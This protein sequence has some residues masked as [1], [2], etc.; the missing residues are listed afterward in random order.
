MCGLVGVVGNTSSESLRVAAEQMSDRL[1]HRGPDDDGLWID[2]AAGVALGHRRLAIVDL[3]PAGHQPMTSACGRWVLVFNGEIYNHA[4]LRAELERAGTAT[5]WRGH[6]DT[7]TLLACFAA[8]GIAET[9]RRSVGMFA[10]GLW[11]RAERRLVLARD[12][13]GEKP[14]YY[15]WGQAD[16]GFVL[17]FASEL[18]ALRAFPGFSNPIDRNALALYFQCGGL[19]APHAIYKDVFKVPPGHFL[20]FEAKDLSLKATRVESYW[21]LTEVIEAGRRDP[22]TDDADAV[23]SLDVALREAIRLQMIADVPLGVF[24]SG[25]VDSSTIAALMQAQSMR[26]VQTFTI[27]FDKAQFNEGDN[28]GAVA[29]HLGTDHTD[30]RVTAQAALA[31]APRLAHLIDEPFADSSIIPTF[32]VCEAARRQVTVALSGDAGDELF[33]GYNRH[34]FLRRLWSIVGRMPFPLRRAVC[35]A[36]LTLPASAL[37]RLGGAVDVGGGLL[38]FSDK[39]QK[40]ARALQTAPDPDT[41]YQELLSYWPRDANPALGAAPPLIAGFEEIVKLG[42]GLEDRMMAWDSLNYLPTDILH[43]MDRAAMGAS[44]ETRAPFLDHRVVELAWRMPAHMKI[45]DGRGKWV[46]RQVLYDYVPPALIDRPKAGFALPLAEW[47][48]GPLRDWAEALLDPARVRREAY[49]DPFIVGEAWK[50]FLAGAS[51]TERI[52]S[53]LIFQ[54]WME[55]GS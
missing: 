43:K 36:V 29:R 35:K 15:G 5:V 33:G 50:S 28:A 39:L 45:R 30:L 17:L 4:S 46:L 8:W 44:L 52:W 31:L 18:K 9:L 2:A 48:R 51:L 16:D 11:D 37:D 20:V 34:L 24:L 53:V 14:L 49:L 25:G 38:H 7:E 54:L 41:L 10:L 6:G 23:E 1:R 3:S 55:A 32:L 12:R 26:R 42:L 13:A 21:R 40:V 22:I 47:L 27:S 19:P